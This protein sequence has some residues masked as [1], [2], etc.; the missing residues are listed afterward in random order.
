METFYVFLLFYKVTFRMSLLLTCVSLLVH[1]ATF[2]KSTVTFFS[3]SPG[4]VQLCKKHC[5]N[6]VIHAYTFVLPFMYF[7]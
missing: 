7:K 4:I 3:Q 2:Y 1:S 5:L 6:K